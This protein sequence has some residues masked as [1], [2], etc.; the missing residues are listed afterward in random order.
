MALAKA[1]AVCGFGQ[2]SILPKAV[3]GR[4]V[5]AAPSRRSCRLW[6]LF[7]VRKTSATGNHRRVMAGDSGRGVRLDRNRPGERNRCSARGLSPGRPRPPFPSFGSSVPRSPVQPSRLDRA[8][9]IILWA[10]SVGI[11]PVFGPDGLRPI[12]L[13]PS[14]VLLVP[15][16]PAGLPG[17][18]R[19]VSDDGEPAAR[20]PER[21][22][23]AGLSGG[24]SR[25]AR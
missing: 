17:C 24:P 2:R 20:P 10:E 25:A 19:R 11:R 3:Q 4:L 14:S 1:D 23:P 18:R 13:F 7:S 22:C 6:A 9:T 8:R 21:T 12:Q 15:P 5:G 16:F